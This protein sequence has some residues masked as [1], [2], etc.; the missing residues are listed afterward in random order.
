[1]SVEY[2]KLQQENQ[3]LRIEL[4][5]LKDENERLKGLVDQAI[6]DGWR[7]TGTK[8]LSEIV[9]DFHKQHNL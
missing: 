9:S 6:I 5:A 7:E 2:P 8:T 4:Q 1:M 3:Q